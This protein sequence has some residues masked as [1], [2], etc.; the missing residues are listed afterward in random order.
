MANVSVPMHNFALCVRMTGGKAD[1]I[2]GCLAVCLSGWLSGCLSVLLS[3]SLSLFACLP[4]CPVSLS[5][6]TFTDRTCPT[7]FLCVYGGLS[8]CLSVCPLSVCPS[9]L[10]RRQSC[11]GCAGVLAWLLAWYRVHPACSSACLY[12]RHV[13]NLCG[14]CVFSCVCVHGSVWLRRAEGGGE[15]VA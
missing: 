7:I 4:V 9:L 2:G 12:T 10:C 1:T 15:G 14:W 13:Y 6:A 5:P 11:H 8:M 3:G